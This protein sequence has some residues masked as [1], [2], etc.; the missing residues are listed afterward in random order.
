MAAQDTLRAATFG[1]R[2]WARAAGRPH[3]LYI[4]F[5][6]AVLRR[7]CGNDSRHDCSSLAD[8]F[9][10]YVGPF[11]GTDSRR[12]AIIQAVRKDLA[13]FGIRAVTTRP[14]ADPGARSGSKTTC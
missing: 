13:D 12:L 1:E 7:G 3:I 2:P 4:N 14:P 8:L 5:D 10:G 9:A 6:G 11:V